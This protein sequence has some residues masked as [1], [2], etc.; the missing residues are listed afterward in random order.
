M[1]T[2]ITRAS[3]IGT[4]SRRKPGRTCCVALAGHHV[5]NARVWRAARD[6]RRER[7]AA[8]GRACARLVA[9]AD[10]TRG[11]RVGRIGRLQARPRP[12]LRCHSNRCAARP[13]SPNRPSACRSIDGTR[14]KACSTASIHGGD[15]ML[16]KDARRCC[17]AIRSAK[18]SACWRA[19][20]RRSGRSSAMAR[21]SRSIA[22]IARRACACRRLAW[23]ARYRQK[24]RR[25]SG[26]R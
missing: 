21:W 6:R 12:D 20:T 13:S 9:S 26:R 10:R 1:P 3:D 11:A 24:T 25:C 22:R 19:S 7:V 2:P 4:T 17:S 8:S 23:S 18:R 15:T 14:R 16:P 5:A